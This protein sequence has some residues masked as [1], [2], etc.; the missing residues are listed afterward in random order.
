MHLVEQGDDDT[1]AGSTNGVAQSDGAAVDVDL[2]HVEVQLT[3]HSDGLS[4]ESLVG[5]DQVD[6]LDGHA[7]LSHS[8]RGKPPRGRRP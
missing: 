6:V 3:G 7:G 5:L 8:V 1:G 2:A 4:S